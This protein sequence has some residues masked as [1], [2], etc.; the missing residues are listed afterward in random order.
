[1]TYWFTADT[2]FGH[3][4]ILYYCKRK[5]KNIKE[6]DY[7]LIQNWNSRVKPEDVVF[8]LGDFC[9]KGEG[10]FDYYRKQLNGQLILIKGNHD[11]SNNVK[12]CIEDIRIHLG[13][14]NILLVHRPEDVGYSDVDVVFCGHIHQHWRFKTID[15][16]NSKGKKILFSIDF[17][18]VG[19]DVWNFY[20]VTINEI[21]SEYAKWKSLNAKNKRK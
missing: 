5:F 1:M 17:I 21:L 8:H 6:H 14:K 9:F 11:N 15:T 2:H 4:K 10:N 20:P 12:T 19:V 16:F 13:G 3:S 18:N 7:R